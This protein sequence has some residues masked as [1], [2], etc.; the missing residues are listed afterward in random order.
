M[1]DTGI[2]ALAL[3]SLGA[4][5]V[6]S[7]IYYVLLVIA[8]WKLYTKAG[9]AGWKSIIPIYN[10]YI[11]YKIS[12]KPMMFWITLVVSIASCIF[13]SIGSDVATVIGALLLIVGIVIEIMQMYKL[14]KAYGH[15]VGYTIGLILLTPI[16]M[17]IL[18]LGSSQY[19]GKDQ[20]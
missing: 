2:I 19:V 14:S 16:F 5:V 11:L 3:G 8:Q 13:Y 4:L 10:S 18:G 1:S 6:I 15:G 9:E 12:W 17:L 20:N 7:I